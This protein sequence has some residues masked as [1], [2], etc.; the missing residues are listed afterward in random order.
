MSFCL[1]FSTVL[2]HLSVKGSKYFLAL[3]A[4]L[5]QENRYKQHINKWAWQC[6]SQIF[7]YK[8]PGSRLDQGHGLWFSNPCLTT[9]GADNQMVPISNNMGPSKVG[10]YFIRPI[11][12]LLMF[13]I[14]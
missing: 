9:S 7:I 13:K 2:T 14:L 8:K 12:K 4:V 1:L 6:S 3:W 5:C 11:Y 10:V